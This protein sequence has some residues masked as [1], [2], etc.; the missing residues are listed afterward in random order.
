[1]RKEKY[2]L[3]TLLSC[4]AVSVLIGQNQLVQYVDPT[5]GTSGHGH[6]FPGA[7]LP[8]GMVQLSPDNGRGGWDWCS[9]YHYSDSSIAGFSHTHICGTGVG[10]L[11][12]ILVMPTTGKLQIHQGHPNMPDSGY[13]SRFSH[14]E[15]TAEAGY[16]AVTLQKYAIRAELT[17]SLRAGMHRYRFP[18][19]D[20]AHILFD[21]SHGVKSWRGDAIWQ[22]IQFI[23][24]S[25]ICGYKINSGWAKDRKIYFA[26]RF[27]KPCEQYGAYDGNSLII[28]NSRMIAGKKVVA[29][30]RFRMGRKEQI[31]VKVGISPVS[32]RNAMINLDTEMPGWDFDSYVHKAKEEW[33]GE[34]QRITIEAPE[35][36]KRTYYTAMYHAMIHP[37]LYMDT[38]GSYNG[39]D[40][41]Y[42][43]AEGFSHYTVFSL[44][45]TY[46][47]WH[48]LMTIIDTK[49]TSDYIQSMLEHYNQSIYGVLPVWSLH[50]WETWCMIG[51]HSI[52]VITDAYR[53]GIRTF[54]AEKALRAMVQSA[55]YAWDGMQEYRTLG[56]VPYDVTHESVSK[57][58][59]YAVDDWCIAHMAKAMEK[60]AIYEQFSKKAMHYKNVY[61]THSGL[62]RPKA[63]DGSWKEN[64]NPL[65]IKYKSDFTEGNA[66]QYTWHAM[67]DVHGL[68]DLMGGK[69]K[70]ITKLDSLFIIQNPAND[71]V[72]DVSGLIGQ[73]AH[74]NEPSHH[75]AYLYNYAGQPW[76]T[77]EKVRYIMQNLYSDKEDGLCG[78]EDCG[79]MSA[80]YLF[81]AIGFYPV[82]P[83]GS[84]YAIG[85]PAVNS[86][87]INLE[88]EK[89]FTIKVYNQNEKNIYIQSMKLNGKP[90]LRYW[91]S[92]KEI[93]EGGTLEFTMSAKANKHTG[94]TK[95]MFPPDYI[96]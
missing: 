57:T 61:D 8:H 77:Q 49:R 37:S 53:K 87:E 26:A 89:K 34:L 12:D 31:L 22:L 58:L 55:E 15:E 83:A 29:Y 44:W 69:N 56:Y 67:H 80:W 72:R 16:Y 6:V 4:I 73:Y 36:I 82:N 52:P 25:T 3:T 70:F 19:T 2:F 93:M 86:A 23:D 60:K 64:F 65:F 54:D 42:H 95:A 45:D 32:M 10:D 33:E 47:A 21:L 46:R 90:L 66:W 85:S 30:L 20:S 39:I 7:C 43:K 40:Q 5:I 17:A 24:D 28:S 96:E 59:E 62:M 63:T 88:N 68:I 74:G 81:S 79:Q 75:V 1:M 27:S 91:I 41:N 13:R 9:G 18:Q 92:H 50:G 84:I 76:K 38:D 11:G 48:P 35:A 51:Y 14:S 71:D 78:N 94:T